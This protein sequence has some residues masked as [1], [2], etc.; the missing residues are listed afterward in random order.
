MTSVLFWGEERKQ[1][2][3]QKAVKKDSK[4]GKRERERERGRAKMSYST[5][6]TPTRLPRIKHDD[7]QILRSFIFSQEPSSGC[8]SDARAHDD[9][10]RLCRE[11]GGSTV[12][13]KETRGFGVPQRGGGV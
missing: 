3:R 13:P 6:S 10:V 5:C 9:K 1:G 12:A 7:V 2:R 8:T 11:K 4:G